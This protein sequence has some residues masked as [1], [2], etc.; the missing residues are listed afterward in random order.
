M[1]LRSNA[2]CTIDQ[3]KDYAGVKDDHKN[4]S[5]EL[6]VN[7]ASAMVDEYLGYDP[8]T[9]TYTEEVYDGNGTKCLITKARPITAITTLLCDG[10]T[11]DIDDFVNRT[12]YIDGDDYVF[13]RG[14]SNYKL[15]YT[16]G[17]SSSTMPVSITLACI[18]I[19]AMMTKEDGRTGSLGTSSI[20]HG[21]G[22]RTFVESTYD[23]ILSSIYEYKRLY[24]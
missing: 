10:D 15:T 7:A 4:D 16:A 24:G 5:L 21:D 11:V 22:S 9:Q 18:K 12:W 1:S 17:Y 2:L 19:A 20:S 3:V 6:Y 14:N 23:S 13:V 8:M